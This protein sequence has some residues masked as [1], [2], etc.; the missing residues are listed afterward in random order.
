[1][2]MWWHGE[3]WVSCPVCLALSL[4]AQY[5][6]F[7]YSIMTSLWQALKVCVCKGSESGGDTVTCPPPRLHAA[8]LPCQSPKLVQS[9]GCPHTVAFFPHSSFLLLCPSTVSILL[10]LNTVQ[11]Y[12]VPALV[13]KNSE[14]SELIALA[15][16]SRWTTKL[17][18]WDFTYL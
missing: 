10:F 15:S 6:Y 2:Y 5:S 13:N 8:A 17:N 16:F 12:C 14:P 7:Q 4:C 3:F 1:M 11:L 18:V 9:A